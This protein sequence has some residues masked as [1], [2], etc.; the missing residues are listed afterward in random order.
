[1]VFNMKVIRSLHNLK[2]YLGEQKVAVTIGNYDGVHRGH[3]VIIQLLKSKASELGL[4]TLVVTFEPQPEEFFAGDRTKRLFGLRDKLAVFSQDGVEFVLI[5][6]FNQKLATLS[7]QE[8]ATN[9]LIKSINIKYLVIGDDFAF[10]HQREGGFQLLTELANRYQFGLAQLD[11]FRIDG[12]RV[13]S[14]LVRNALLADNLKLAARLLGRLYAVNGRVVH[15]KHLGRSL[16]FPTA[17]LHLK[18]ELPLSGVY[19]V[20]VRVF[21]HKNLFGIANIGFRPTFAGEHKSFE[22]YIFDF[23]QDIY[24]NRVTVEFCHKIR[25]ERRFSSITALQDQINQ[26]L[27]VAYRLVAEYQ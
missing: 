19:L 12:V 14:T 20:K 25:D 22:V 21:N 27:Q 1:M 3:Q 23:N 26:D 13:S 24:Y 10:G 2:L 7:A 17:N 15:G 6:P 4:S 5:L 16:G 9:I 18:H 8:F 11:S